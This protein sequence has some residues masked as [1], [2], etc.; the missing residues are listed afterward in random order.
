MLS[1]EREV[2]VS[3]LVNERVLGFGMV[4]DVFKTVIKSDS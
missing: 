1:W 2:V 3:M 4:C